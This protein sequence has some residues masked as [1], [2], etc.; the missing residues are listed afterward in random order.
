[1]VARSVRYS[2]LVDNK[3]P[4]MSKRDEAKNWVHGYTT[5]GIGIVIAAI[6]PGS[7]SLALMGLDATMAYHIGK[8]YKDLRGG[9]HASWAAKG[10]EYPAPPF[11]GIR[12]I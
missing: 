2:K 7:T 10:G 8:I 9:G 12:A 5:V 6:I 3:L 1:M 4:A 11:G